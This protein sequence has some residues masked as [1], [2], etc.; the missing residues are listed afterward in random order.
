MGNLQLI[1]FY[2]TTDPDTHNVT[3]EGG[4]EF[5]HHVKISNLLLRHSNPSHVKQ[6][7]RRQI[8]A[9]ITRTIIAWIKEYNPHE[10]QYE[11]DKARHELLN[12]LHARGQLL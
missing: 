6:A 2:E 10:L 3:I 8:A 11:L 12:D 7:V 1:D 4:I 9:G 5:R